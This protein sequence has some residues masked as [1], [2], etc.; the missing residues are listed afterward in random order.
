VDTEEIIW[1]RDKENLSWR[2]IGLA[3]GMSKTG[4]QARYRAATDPTFN[5]WR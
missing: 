3:V 4:A 2:E 1:L 5:R